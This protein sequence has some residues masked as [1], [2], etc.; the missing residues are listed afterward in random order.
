MGLIVAPNP[1]AGRATISYSV[2]AGSEQVRIALTDLLGREVRVLENGPKA[3]GTQTLDLNAANLAAG[4]YLVKV[5][6]GARTATRK[7]VLL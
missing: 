4:T 1:V 2:A 5:Q 3:A 7:V 6:Q